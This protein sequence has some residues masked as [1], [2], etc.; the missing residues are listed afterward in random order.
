MN[1][2]YED[3]QKGYIAEVLRGVGVESL[4]ERYIGKFYPRANSREGNF[5]FFAKL[6]E[7]LV[8]KISQNV[9]TI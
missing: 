8:C 2:F 4:P 9:P 6:N 5:A 1:F 3:S 7:N